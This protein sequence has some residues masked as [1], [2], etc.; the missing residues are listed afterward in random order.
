MESSDVIPPRKEA[1]KRF[2]QIGN[3][4]LGLLKTWKTNLLLVLLVAYCWRERFWTDSVARFTCP[5]IVFLLSLPIL[6]HC[7]FSFMGFFRKRKAS[8]RL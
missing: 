2:A 4:F 1:T 5:L 6:D 3:L 7:G 8:P